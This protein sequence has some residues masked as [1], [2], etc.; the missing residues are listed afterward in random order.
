M[1][2]LK[3]ADVGAYLSRNRHAARLLGVTTLVVAMSAWT[4]CSA[5]RT[6]KEARA[7]TWEAAAIG[8]TATRFSR[9]FVPATI[10]ETEEWAR[11]T[12]EAAAFG[13]PEATKV[14]LAQTVSRIAEV[15]GM[16]TVKAS[17]IP[18]DSVGLADTRRMGD[19]TFEPGTFGLRLEA[20]GTVPALARVILRLPPATEITSLS[21]SGHT[22][23]L[24]ATFHL[25][26]YHP[27]GGPQN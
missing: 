9:Q 2:D 14:S 7:A 22:D 25:A 18:P 23:Q 5:L 16:S 10:G 4:S 8:E 26:V 17:F 11:T 24:K 1:K 27:A 19:L 21:I 3:L 13:A 12:E 15:A 6:T 20:N